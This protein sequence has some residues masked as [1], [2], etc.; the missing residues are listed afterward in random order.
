LAGQVL[1]VH[2]RIAI[3]ARHLRPRVAGWP[4]RL[5]ETR[6]AADL[7]AALA[8]SACPIVL[9]DVSARP[10]NALEDLGRAL[11]AAPE[12]LVLVLNPGALDG[13]AQVARELGA[14]H[15]IDGPATPPAVAALLARW[16]P[17]AQRRAEAAGRVGS[18][19]AAAEVEPGDWLTPLLGA[20][21]GTLWPSRD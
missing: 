3:W 11:G 16:L 19:P 4:V 13:V 14:A 17:L 10:R 1:V 12:A 5:V 2:E 21:A 7:E 9:V 18:A 8:G 15:V 6:S 20:R